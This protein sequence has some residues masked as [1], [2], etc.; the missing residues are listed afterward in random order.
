MKA[1]ISVKKPQNGSIEA[2]KWQHESHK[3]AV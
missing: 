1:D 3:M 2:M